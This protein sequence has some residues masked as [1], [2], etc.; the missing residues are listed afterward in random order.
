MLII[1]K[2]YEFI[3]FLDSI[4]IN[5]QII[6]KRPIIR[7]GNMYLR[8]EILLSLLCNISMQNVNNEMWLEL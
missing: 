5:Q 1:Y 8:I 6:D 3:F 7:N 4:L 2:I